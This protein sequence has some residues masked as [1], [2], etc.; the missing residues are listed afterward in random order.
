MNE[1][2]RDSIQSIDAYVAGALRGQQRQALEAHVS[3][4]PACRAE[5]A[6]AMATREARAA[7]AAPVAPDRA[8][9][10]FR[11]VTRSLEERAARPRG[12]SRW[13]LRSC[14]RRRCAPSFRARRAWQLSLAAAAVAVVLAVALLLVV[15]ER[16]TTTTTT[17]ASWV[18]RAHGVRAWAEPGCVA[19]VAR[20]ERAIEL[21]VRRGTLLVAFER[22]AAQGPLRVRAPG[23]EVIARD[24][25]FFVARDEGATTVG[26]RRGDVELR[27]RGQAA[28]LVAA[29]EQVRV[30]GLHVSR[31]RISAVR[32]ERL[33]ERFG[34][35]PVGQSPGASPQDRAGAT[36]AARARRPRRPRRPRRSQTRR[37]DRPPDEQT[38]AAEAGPA[39]PTVP[40]VAEIITAARQ[41]LGRGETARAR[42]LL[43]KTLARAGGLAVA[44]REELLYLLANT[45][46]RERRLRE[47]VDVL[48][49]L[50]A[51]SRSHAARMADLERA[52]L[53]AHSLHRP[54]QALKVLRRLV[55][56]GGTDA[57]AQQA[58]QELC[59]LYVEQRAREDARRCIDTLL[60]R[61]KSARSNKKVL[62]L[63]DRLEALREK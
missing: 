16:P 29:Y 47:A 6:L 44:E 27:R 38:P 23:L 4:C 17:G 55:N 58:W 54:E 32:L 36:R 24:A 61:F 51:S 28:Q 43:R 42:E 5:L 22:S 8:A 20:R 50:A 46:R 62:E 18:A 59:M 11:A 49:Q 13:S 33:V 19:S 26:V 60:R 2:C 12:R 41:H 45:L 53:L 37:A 3:G 14:A 39:P 31:Q 1:A 25:V 35:D 63:R 57:L 56:R 34:E 52:R 7:A 48:G 40:S 10:I 30:A 15:R 9:R 21:D